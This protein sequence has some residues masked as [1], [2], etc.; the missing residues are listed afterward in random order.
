MDSWNS[1]SIVE[2]MNAFR[3]CS[4]GGFIAAEEKEEEGERGKTS[5]EEVKHNEPACC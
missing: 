5:Q 1:R 3:V 2:K 4:V